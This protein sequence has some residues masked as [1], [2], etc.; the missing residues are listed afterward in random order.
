MLAYILSYPTE[1]ELREILGIACRL[2]VAVQIPR[3]ESDKNL[4]NPVSRNARKYF[5]CPIEKA[6]LQ[7]KAE[8]QPKLSFI[9]KFNW[10]CSKLVKIG[11]EEKHLV[12]DHT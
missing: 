12:S 8:K 9:T 3:N 7:S 5:F 6:V 2:L 4:G 11:A 1:R 10:L